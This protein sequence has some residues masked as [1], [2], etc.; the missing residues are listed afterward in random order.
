MEIILKQLKKSGKIIFPQTSAEAVL[1]KQNNNIVTLNKALESKQ[2]V[3]ITPADSGLAQVYQN[4]T[5][6][7]THSN[8]ITANEKPQ[9]LLIKYDS[10]GHITETVPSGKTTIS[11]QNTPIIESDNSEDQSLNFTDDFEIIDKNN[12][13]LKFNNL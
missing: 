3:I 6:I 10:H 13:K 11:V 9:A 7:L 5:V 8:N 2:N 1:V 12:I 4:N